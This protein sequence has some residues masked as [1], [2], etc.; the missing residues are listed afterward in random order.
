MKAE[1]KL[2]RELQKVKEKER[3][4]EQYRRVAKENSPSMHSVAF[5]LAVIEAEQEIQLLEEWN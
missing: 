5:R 2:S 1:T 3:Y 4:L